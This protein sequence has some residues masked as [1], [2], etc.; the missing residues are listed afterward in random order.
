MHKISFRDHH[1]FQLLDSYDL[2]HLPLDLHIS[3]YFADNKALGS[4]DRAHIADTT[5]NIVRWLSLYDHLSGNTSWESRYE[6]HQQI[7]PLS[8]LDNEEI[9][10]HIRV[11][12][13][14][15]L[16]DLILAAH[17]RE[18]AIRICLANNTPA[19]TTVRANALK[20]S[21]DDLLAQWIGYDVSPSA[22]AP[23]G[24]RFHKK[25]AFFTLQEFRN[26]LFEVQDEASQLVAD[27]VKA[28]PGQSVMDYCAGSGG[29]TLAFAPAMNQRG[30]I[31]LHDIR[32]GVLA[33]AKR[34]L[35]RAGI[36][37]AQV[38]LPD[39]N[40]LSKLKKKMD[41]VLADVP[42]TGS[43]TLRRN[44]DMKWKLTPETLQKLVAQQ[45]TIFE[46]ALSFMKPEGR[47]V[48]ATCSILPQ[49]N[50]DQIEHFLRTY[51][52]EL[53]RDPFR[54]IPREGEMDGFFG[55]VLRRR[56]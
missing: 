11:S 3:N 8:F 21:R 48:Y 49:E 38:V 6:Q 16:F 27:L 46:R 37:N 15:E 43:G 34:R 19:P 36:Q 31:Y 32:L 51:N 5:Y 53:E 40:N 4:K 28:A 20:T 26:G 52:L 35:R 13:P 24:I 33:E 18:E 50:N 23:C 54:S 7:D 25:I 30:Q 55:A 1:L 39:S 2:Q 47:I 42:C 29:K 9:P 41:W 10:L 22:H 12:Y 56:A 45:R 44:P 17:G 14:K